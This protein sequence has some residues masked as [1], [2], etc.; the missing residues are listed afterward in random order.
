MWHQTAH[1]SI[2][3][4]IFMCQR[5]IK[6]T[7]WLINKVY[8]LMSREYASFLHRMWHGGLLHPKRDRMTRN[9]PV[10]LGW[11]LG[12]HCY[13]I[14]AR[15]S[16]RWKSNLHHVLALVRK[17]PLTGERHPA[18]VCFCWRRTGLAHPHLLSRSVQNAHNNNIPIIKDAENKSC[19]WVLLAWWAC[20]P[21]L[22]W[23]CMLRLYA[24]LSA[25]FHR[26]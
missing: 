26:H 1:Q 8:M 12:S 20:F 17:S 15:E 3:S 25:A 5:L 13:Q 10:D 21:D 7:I 24:R 23:T 2:D 18:H 19:V 14:S 11:W 16:V 4:S 9:R 22:I 6:W